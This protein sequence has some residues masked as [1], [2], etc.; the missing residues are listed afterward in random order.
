MF[1]SSCS[2]CHGLSGTEAAGKQGGDLAAF[3]MTEAQIESETRVM[4]VVRRPLTDAQ[5]RAVS[6]YILGVQRA[7]AARAG[8]H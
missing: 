6:Q 4:P 3:T 2:V 7:Y 8:H 5:V 1:A